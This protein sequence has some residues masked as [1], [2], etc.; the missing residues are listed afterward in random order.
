LK[1]ILNKI[2]GILTLTLLSIVI[3]LNWIVLWVYVLE[4]RYK[5]VSIG[6]HVMAIIIAFIVLNKKTQVYNKMS[7]MLFIVLVPILGCMCYFIFGRSELTKKTREKLSKTH[8][9]YKKFLM[10]E[11]SD[12]ELLKLRDSKNAYKLAKYMKNYGHYPIYKSDEAKYYSNIR[13]LFEEMLLDIDKAQKFV[14]IEFFIVDKGYMLDR[15]MDILKKKIKQGV[16]VRF[17]YDDIGCINTMKTKDWKELSKFGIQFAQFNK[18]K[19]IV[20]VVMNN[21]DHRKNVIIDGKIAYTGGFNL[22]D[23]YINRVE[24]F[25]YW[26]DAGIK[27]T[28]KAVV[29][30]TVM[31]LEMWNFIKETLE[32]PTEYIEFSKSKLESYNKIENRK[33]DAFLLPYA[34]S[35]LDYETVGENVYLNVINNAKKYVYIFTPYLII[36]SEMNKALVNAAKSGVDVRIITPGIPDKKMVFLA[37]QSSY[38]PLIEGGVKIFQ[39][40]PG[41]VHAKCCICDGKYGVVGTIN[42]DFRSFFLHYES[43]VLMYKC[44]AIEHLKQDFIETFAVCD[45]VTLEFTK[46]RDYCIRFLQSILRAFAPL[47]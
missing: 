29:N 14:F 47:L 39:Y 27:F 11:K 44:S 23:E 30:S 46:R 19:P 2:F 9:Y 3:Q 33:E 18:F 10:G 28:G 36:D 8:N 31:F 25:G 12:A 16:E 24:R 38:E 42:F 41:F 15:L 20:S 17:I 34:D 13:E 32:D 37:T 22:A 7:W 43:A 5:Y 21:R 1:K 35:P 40:S 4:E 45:K 26:K 6:A